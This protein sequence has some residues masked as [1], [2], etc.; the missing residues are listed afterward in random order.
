ME[1]EY[2]NYQENEGGSKPSRGVDWVK[3][4]L[5]VVA[6]VLLI[7]IIALFIFI[8]ASDGGNGAPA[9]KNQP[10][11]GESAV[12]ENQSEAGSAAPAKEYNY[13][14]PSQE[15][16]QSLSSEE[17]I[18]LCLDNVTAD[19]AIQGKNLSACYEIKNESLRFACISR[20]A[21]GVQDADLCLETSDSL[22]RYRCVAMIASEK[23]DP[24][25]CD[26]LS[27]LEDRQNCQDQV[28]AFSIAWDEDKGSLYKCRKLKSQEYIDLCFLHSFVNKFGG[29]CGAVPQN[30]R[31]ECL[32]AFAKE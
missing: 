29:D 16:C 22:A 11:G 2:E 21:Q 5:F 20:V 15:S 23:N 25:L 30:Y 32:D 10:A 1:Q 7:V 3:L 17:E 18:Q 13:Q 12:S 28:A 31:Q 26:K 6:G 8:K 24:A 4:A 19:R 9:E 27:S 14:A